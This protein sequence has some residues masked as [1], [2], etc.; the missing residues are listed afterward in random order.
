MGWD[1]T[2][3]REISGGRLSGPT[4]TNSVMCFRHGRFPVEILKL[5]RRVPVTVPIG[6]FR[7]RH[8]MAVSSDFNAM[9]STYLEMV[10]ATSDERIERVRRGLPPAL[11][12]QLA[13]DLRIPD[14]NLAL[15][16][17]LNRAVLRR[18]IADDERLSAQ[19]SDGPLAMAMLAGGVVMASRQPSVHPVIVADPLGWLGR[20]IR[21]P[22][23]G[24]EGRAPIQY[25]D[26]G[27]GRALV[28]AWL[29]SALCPGSRPS[30]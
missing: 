6:H 21:T 15:Y 25:M 7:E 8:D 5:A 1:P 22:V 29:A 16:L 14:R 3:G 4:Y 19:E 9:Y 2:Y 26:V 18:R 27:E 11:V 12:V 23:P 30:A 13:Q 17:G 10:Q 28:A 24:L 20:W